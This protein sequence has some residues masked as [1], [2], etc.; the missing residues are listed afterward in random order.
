M[1]VTE[2]VCYTLKFLQGME[3]VRNEKCRKSFA[4]L[5]GLE[6]MNAAATKCLVKMAL[7]QRLW[8]T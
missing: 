1:E 8:I 5:W 6:I 4:Y 3:N 7:Q 2:N